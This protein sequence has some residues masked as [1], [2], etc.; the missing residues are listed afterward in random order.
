M[1]DR[2]APYL[3]DLHREWLACDAA[4]S[5]RDEDGSLAFDISGFTSLTERLAKRGK[6]GVE[7]LIDTLNGVLAPLVGTA[8]ALGGDTLNFGG[9]A[10][11]VLF[12]GSDHARRACAAAWDMQ[13]AMA[14]FRRMR[15][16]AGIVSLR[17]FGRHR[18]GSRPCVPRRR[19]LP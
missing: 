9:D 1:V 8:G 12:S 19:P 17:A 11:L 18:L 10:L 4:S 7:Q 5:W 14:P 3:C 2:L 6:A 16:D 15:T 13:D